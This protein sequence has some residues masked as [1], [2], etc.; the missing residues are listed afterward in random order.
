MADVPQKKTLLELAAD[1]FG[2]DILPAEKKLFGAAEEGHRADCGEESGAKGLVRS[3]RLAWLCTD[4]NARSRVKYQGVSICGAEIQ[5][6]VNLEWANISFPFQTWC[7]VFKETLILR[8]SHILYLRV[9][10]T[11]FEAG[12]DLMGATIEGNL[13]CLGS[14]FASKG[15]LWALQALGAKINGSVFL[16][17]LA[18]GELTGF[19]AKGG[20]NLQAATIEGDLI[21]LG[22]QFTSNG[23]TSSSLPVE[24][25]LSPCPPMALNAFAAKIKGS[26]YLRGF[27]AEGGGSVLRHGFKAEGGVHFR[28]ATIEGSLSCIDGQFAGGLNLQAA[29]IERDLVCEGEGSQFAPNKG[30]KYALDANGAKIGG[31]VLLREGIPDRLARFVLNSRSS[32]CTSLALAASGSQSSGHLGSGSNSNFSRAVPRKYAAKQKLSTAETAFVKNP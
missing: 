5:G 26:V 9:T 2:Q 17:C 3:V 10:N 1:R 23:Q 15:K 29:T 18:E 22:S 31:N 19:K 14:Q 32:A 7:C 11:S 28:A 25:D 20:V 24:D 12:V 30:Q 21:C 4:P 8:N 27:K 16:S 13:D 6:E